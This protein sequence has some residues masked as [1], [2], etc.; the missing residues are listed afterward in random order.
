MQAR[1]GL[2]LPIIQAPMAGVQDG[3]LAIAAAPA[4]SLGP[5]NPAAS[6][7]P[8]AASGFVSMRARSESRGCGDSSPLRAVQNASACKKV[9]AGVLTRVMLG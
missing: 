7:L 1:L 8:W 4:G 2:E 9:P 6:A 3:P 5:M